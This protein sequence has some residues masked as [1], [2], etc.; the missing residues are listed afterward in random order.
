MNKAYASGIACFCADLTVNPFTLEF[1]KTVAARIETLPEL[2]IG[3]VESN[4]AQNYVNWEKMLGYHPVAGASFIEA[5]N[6]LYRLDGKFFLSSGG[7]FGK[8]AYYDNIFERK[9][10]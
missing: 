10:G 1:N 9:P 7:I 5:K 3:I 2:K 8:S 4:G 6:G